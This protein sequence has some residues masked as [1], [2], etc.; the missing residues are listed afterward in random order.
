VLLFSLNNYRIVASLGLD[1]LSLVAVG[2][3]VDTGARPNL[4]RRSALAPDWLHRVVTSKEEARVRLRDANNA[5]LRTSGT[6]TLW[7]QTGARIGPVTFLV[8]DHLSVPV[9][10]GCLFIGD[11]AHAILPQDRSI[12]LTEGSVTAFLRGPLDDGNRSMGVSCVL[13]ATCRTRLS[14]SSASVVWVWTMWGGLGQVLGASRLFTTHGITIANGVHVNVPGLSF[15]VIVTNIGTRKVV[16]RQRVSVG[17]VVLL[18]TN[19]VQVSLAAHPGTSAVPAFTTPT[20]AESVVGAVGATRGLPGPNRD[21]G[22]A[23]IAGGGAATVARPRDPGEAGSSPGG[24]PPLV[25]DADP[26]LH[27]RIRHMLGQHQAMWTGQALS[28]IKAAQRRIDLNAGARPVRFAPRRAGHTARVAETAE[29]KRQLESDVIEPTSWEWGFPVVLVPK[30]DGTLRFCVDY[31][32]LNVVTKKDTYPLPRMDECIDSLGEATIFSTLDCNAG[33]WQVA[34]APEDRDKTAF[35]CHE[36]AY[37]YKRMPFGLTNA[38]ATFQRAL[39]II[40]SGVKWQSRLIFLDD[41]IVCST[42]EEEHIGHVAHVLRLLREAGVTLRLPKCRSFRTTVQYL[43]H[44]IKPGR[45]GV[46]D[47]QTRA[48]RETHFPTTRTQVR[49]FVGMC[50]VFRRFVPNFSRMAAPLTDIMGSTAPVL[51]PSATPLQQQAFD[52]L[53]EAITTPPVLALPRRGRKDV[54]DVD[55]CGTQV[56]AALLQEQDDGK[57]QTVAYISRRLATKELPYGVTEKKCLAVVWASLKLRPYLEGD[58]FLVRTN[59]DCLRWILNIEGSGN[60]RLARWRLRLSELEFDVAYKPGMTHYLADSI[61]RLESGASDETAFD[62]AVPEFATRANTVRGLDAANYVGDPTVRGINWDEV[63]SAQ[64]AD[65]YCQEFVKALNAGRHIPFFE[66]PEWILLRRAAPDGAHQVVVPAALKE[67]VLHLEHDATLAGHPGESRMY[68]AM[69]RYYYWVGMAAN[70][71]FYVSKCDSCALQRVRPLARRSPLTLFPATM[72][73]QD[74][75]VD[76]Y[77]PHARTAAGHR[78][79]LVITDRFTKLVQELQMDGTT[80]VNCASAVL[81]YWVAAYGPPDRL[82]SDGGPQFT[83]NVWGQVCNLLSIEPKVTS[84]SHP[85]TNGQAERFNRTMHTILDHYVAEHARSWDQLLGALT[86]AYDSRPHRSTGVAPLELVNPMGVSS[87]AFKDVSRTGAYQVTAQRGTAAEK[88]AE[89][90]LLT[91]LVQLVPQMRATLKATQGRYKRDHDRRLALRAEKLTVGGVAWL[92]DHAKEEGAGGKPTHVARGPYRVVST[93]GQTVLLDVDGEHRRENVAHVVRASG[94]A[95]SG[96]AQ[97][98]A[99]RAARSFHGA[100]ADGQQYA[101]DRMADHA[102]LPDGT[103]RVQVYWTGYPQP[104]WMDAAD[105]PHEMLRVYLRRAARLGLPHTSS[106]PPPTPSRAPG[107]PVGAAGGAAAPSPP[108]VRA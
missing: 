89:A 54:L 15:P 93:D 14:P 5:R 13:L 31:R 90:D 99:L 22:A 26:A 61:S 91:R 71:L 78:F 47:A 59:H 80:A 8:V 45:L 56:G 60:P 36:G 27:T 37:Q 72:P 7:I 97:H 55:A 73:F 20:T 64:A 40:L 9:I 103:L 49:S 95:A 52:R 85:Q 70:V 92:R 77:G 62:D 19:V 12:R 24:A 25:L 11:N 23:V 28:V 44:E 29:V 30:K 4:V 100:E 105:A 17:Y 81:D 83:S 42:T 53:K 3:V 10:L 65:G 16:L 33:Y 58:R 87:W 86:L 39:D 21:P 107:P 98:P 88:R 101:V 68:A 106:D 76:L 43:G 41:V 51:V 32:L 50:N 46:M 1:K 67:Q 102:T 57:L 63:L 66:E 34:I 75:A 94:A 35:V 38:P 48:P 79:I 108:N 2:V 69:G 6:V 84:P 82:L 104:Y 74:I 96:P 18:T